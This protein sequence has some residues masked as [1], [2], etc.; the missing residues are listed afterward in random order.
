MNAQ[1]LKRL[2]TR[3]K[4]AEESLK[5]AKA[6]VEAYQAVAKA[7]E[8][9]I[10][11]TRAAIKELKAKKPGI[12]VT[13]HAM[14]RFIERILGISLDEIKERIL[15]PDVVA[16]IDKMGDGKFPHPEGGRLVVKNGTVVT[17]EPTKG[18]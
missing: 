4:N 14:L 12:I 10:N 9:E 13:E 1:D 2:E 5:T 18:E 7:A 6:S 3:L 17:V 8:K 16:L 15:P 11:E